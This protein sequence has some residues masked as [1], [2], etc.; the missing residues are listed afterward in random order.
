LNKDPIAS[1]IGGSRVVRAVVKA[2]SRLVGKTASE[3]D[4]AATYKAAIVAIQ[5]VDGKIPLE[6]LSSVV[7]QQGDT[8]FLQVSV[9]SALL[10]APSTAST[11]TTS[12]GGGAPG[13]LNR[14]FR[15]S[16]NND[17]TPTGLDSAEN[18][19]G[20]SEVD[21]ETNSEFFTAIHNDLEVV[22]QKTE[23]Q[24]REF[25]TAMRVSQ[26]SALIGKT[27]AQSGIDKL[28][29]LYLV[30]LERPTPTG[31]TNT[32]LEFAEALAEG[33]VLWFVGTARAIGDLRKIPVST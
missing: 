26:R 5:K 3:I 16:N 4:F 7:F 1:K 2:G 27:A 33:D 9:D 31:T 18:S 24:D 22:F 23:V 32:T 12:G 28:P 25:M 19:S 30:S 17:N 13:R 6:N 10:T 20:S 21:P 14:L 29:S 11:T 15:S 8:L